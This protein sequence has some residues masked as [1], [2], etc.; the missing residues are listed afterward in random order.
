M[1]LWLNEGGKKIIASTWFKRVQLLCGV[2]FCTDC[3]NIEAELT[4][5]HIDWPV[6]YK[7]RSFSRYETIY[8]ILDSYIVLWNKWCVFFPDFKGGIKVK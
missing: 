7:D 3:R 2:C 4:D 1:L 5:N 8:H 6:Q